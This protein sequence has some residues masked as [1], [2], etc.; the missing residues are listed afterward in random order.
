MAVLQRIADAGEPLNIAQLAAQTRLPAAD[1]LPDRRRADRGRA[2]HRKSARRDLRARA[3]ADVA[4]EPQL[5]TL[6]PAR[7]RHRSVA[8]VA[9]RHSGNRASRRAQRRGD[10]VHREAGEPARRADG[11]AYRHAGHAL[12]ELGGQG[13]S[14][15]ARCARTRDALLQGLRLE[16]FTANT[17]VEPAHSSPNS[18]QHARVAMRKIGKKTKHRFSA[19]AAQSGAR[20]VSRQ[21]ASA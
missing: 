19:T 3:A 18:K 9:R 5:G 4:G 8:D 17:I 16:R 1:G 14:G 10:G 15:V 20:T 13:V 2:R 11:L 7:R 6:R 21:P 12:F